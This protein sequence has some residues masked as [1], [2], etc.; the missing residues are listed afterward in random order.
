MVCD[1]VCQAPKLN[2]FKF[3]GNAIKCGGSKMGIY[4]LAQERD[5]K[6]KHAFRNSRKL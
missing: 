1:P 6:C 2:K 5:L 3:S 4:Y